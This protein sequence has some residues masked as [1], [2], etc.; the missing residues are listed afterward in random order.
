MI[1]FFRRIRQN[2]ISKG[3]NVKY[4]KYAVGEIVLVVIGILIALQV[5]NWNEKQKQDAEF[6]IVLEQ[7]YNA[8]KNDTEAFNAYENRIDEQIKLIDTLLIKPESFP[9]ELLPHILGYLAVEDINNYISETNHHISNLKYNI[10]NPKQNELSKQITSYVNLINKKMDLGLV[11]R[12]N[13]LFYEIGIAEPSWNFNEIVNV[14]GIDN[15]YSQDDYSTLYDLVRTSRFQVILKTLRSYK[16]SYLSTAS[17]YY[18]D[19]LSIMKLIKTYYPN[20]KLLYQDVGIIGT[21]INGYD[22]VGAK[23]T[24]LIQTDIEN[25]IWEVDLYLKKGTVKFRCRD[26]WNQNWGGT[27]FPNGTAE[28]DGDNILIEEGNYHIV[29]NLSENR[30]EFIKV[31]EK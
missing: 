13:P 22:D 15:Y 4:F 8:V 26:S 12:I 19:G 1:K 2:L 16:I 30:Y 24:P 25:S 21:S 29:L 3:K 31:D 28:T 14:N 18:A 17:N 10:N 11:D 20:V 6:E 23:S 9:I 5:N 27:S 7:F